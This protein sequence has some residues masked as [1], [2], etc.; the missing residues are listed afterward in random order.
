MGEDGCEQTQQKN[1]V[2]ITGSMQTLT[3]GPKG[4]GRIAQTG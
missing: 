2:E 3:I 1:P 4:L